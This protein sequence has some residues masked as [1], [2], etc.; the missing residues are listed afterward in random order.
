M[1]PS[2]G[3]VWEAFNHQLYAFIRRR[4]SDEQDAEDLLQEVFLRVHTR[5]AGLR[6]QERIA[7]WLYQVARNSVIDYYRGR[8]EMAPLTERFPQLDEPAE[9]DPAAEIAA[10]LEEMVNSL[11]DPYRETLLL[12]EI[13]GKKHKEIA[14]QLGI[15]LS[16]VKSRVQRGRELL[17]QDLW[18][19][20]H[21]EF[22]RAGRLIHYEPR[23]ECC[24]RCSC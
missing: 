5:L 21:F 10:G 18:S 15:S 20:C 1:I 22:D 4:V 16:G 6:D 7:P 11:P 9:P 13:Q 12:S 19:C 24:P 17:R 8:R 23:P 2:T 14:V 3:E